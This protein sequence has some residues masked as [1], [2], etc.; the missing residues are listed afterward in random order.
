MNFEVFG[1]V[2]NP[3]ILSADISSHSKLKLWGKQRNLILKISKYML[4]VN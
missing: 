3:Y 4:I 2:V 1:N